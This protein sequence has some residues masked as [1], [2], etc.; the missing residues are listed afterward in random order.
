MCRDCGGGRASLQ[1]VF[2]HE[3]ADIRPGQISRADRARHGK[4]DFIA[5]TAD[6]KIAFV[7]ALAS[8]FRFIE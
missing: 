6:A 7:T 2:P 3:S 5:V 4:G 1:V 8:D